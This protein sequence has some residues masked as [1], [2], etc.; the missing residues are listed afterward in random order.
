MG[1]S[2]EMAR[3]LLE[4]GADPSLPDYQGR[5]ARKL[6][7]DVGRPEIAELFD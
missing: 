3:L 2:A 6:A 1:G 4:R 5:G 7:E